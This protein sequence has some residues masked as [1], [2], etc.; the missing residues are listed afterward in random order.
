MNAEPS[1]KLVKK[2]ERKGAEPQA[3]SN[4]AS[5]W[6]DGPQPFSRGFVNFKSIVAA[7]RCQLSTLCS[8]DGTASQLACRTMRSES[9]FCPVSKCA[10]K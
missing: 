6:I 10:T 7:N 9:E 5:T 4:V 8:S 2:G 3:E 1:V